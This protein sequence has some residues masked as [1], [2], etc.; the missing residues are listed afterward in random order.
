MKLSAE[1]LDVTL[2]GKAILRDVS[3]A[4]SEGEWWMQLWLGG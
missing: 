3:C 1:H 2:D 4:V